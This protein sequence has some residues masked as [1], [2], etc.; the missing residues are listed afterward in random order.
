[1][2]ERPG[3][4]V[5]DWLVNT[6]LF[7]QAWRAVCVGAPNWWWSSWICTAA[8]IFTAI[9]W[10][11]SELQ[12]MSELT[13]A[14][15]RGIKYP[16][17]YM[18]LGQLV[19]ISVAIALFLTAVYLHEPIPNRKPKAP[20]MLCFMLISAQVAMFILPEL[21]DQPAFVCV[22]GFIHAAVVIPLFF[23]PTN[24]KNESGSLPFGGLFALLIV[25]AAVIH[26]FT[27]VRVLDM[28]PAAKWL[29][30]FLSKIVLSHPAQASVSLDV[31][32]VAITF[33]AW[34]VVKGSMPS[35]IAKVSAIAAAGAVGAARY[36]G[37][38]WYLI[39]S[40]LPILVLLGVAAAA[41]GLSTV[42][43]RND[44]KRAALL[45]K[46]GIKEYGVIPGTDTEPPAMAKKRTIVGFWHPYW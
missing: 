19:A 33:F 43:S 35:I 2:S 21:A 30:K 12:V 6:S 41:Y 46:L 44:D 24:G 27:T 39:G 11:E 37:V 8:I 29:P 40:F 15:R 18:I 3:A 10:S 9:I 34:W 13:A 25:L 28:L 4:T 7:A 16:V 5:G 20:L 45:E 17:V 32:W 1:M 22:L 14:F 26:T 42:R 31:V 38:N 36:L 23:I